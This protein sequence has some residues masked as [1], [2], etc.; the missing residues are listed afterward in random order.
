MSG[1]AEL[2]P[3]GDSKY[4]ID[5]LREQLETQAQVLAARDRVIERQE[6]MIEKACEW[7]QK[8]GC[9]VL[10]DHYCDENC[11]TEMNGEGCWRRWLE[12]SQ[13]D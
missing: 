1:K 13:H 3:G 9:P 8:I 5:A 10:D 2:F 12:E 4:I 6:R 11:S 7:M